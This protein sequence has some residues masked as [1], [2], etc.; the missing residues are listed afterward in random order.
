MGGGGGF[1]EPFER[2]PERVLVDV[3]SGYVSVEAAARDYGVVIRQRGRH[4][5]LDVA[6]TQLARGRGPAG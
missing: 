1:G 5:E 3:R 6:A 2:P 4:V